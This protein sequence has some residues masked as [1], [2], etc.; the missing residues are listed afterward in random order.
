MNKMTRRACLTF[1]M[2]FALSED[3]ICHNLFQMRSLDS[4][5]R[6]YEH[7]DPVYSIPWKWRLYCVKHIH[8]GDTGVI[9]LFANLHVSCL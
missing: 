3:I 4:V 1:G 9:G 6:Q 8:R 2:T 5:A 7:R